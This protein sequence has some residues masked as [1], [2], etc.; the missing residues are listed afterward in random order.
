MLVIGGATDTR[1]TGGDLK[2]PNNQ[3]VK[4]SGLTRLRFVDGTNSH[5]VVQPAQT[6]KA[7]LIDNDTGTDVTSK[8]VVNPGG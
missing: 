2:Q 3:S 5:G 8:V 6:N 4:V 7:Q 1:I